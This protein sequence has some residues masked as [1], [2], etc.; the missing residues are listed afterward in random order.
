MTTTFDPFALVSY[1]DQ[2]TQQVK[3]NTRYITQR[4]TQEISEGIYVTDDGQ[5]IKVVRTRDGE[6]LYGEIWE[7]YSFR[8]RPGAVRLAAEGHPITSDEAAWFGKEYHHCILC[9]RALKDK[10]STDVGYGRV[11]ANSRGWPWGEVEVT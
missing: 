7:D 10:R 1:T 5:Y 11:C 2:P 9:N 3:C 8:Y 4:N 6:R